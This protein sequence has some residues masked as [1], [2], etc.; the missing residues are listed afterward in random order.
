MAMDDPAGKP[1]MGE[2][3][4]SLRPRASVTFVDATQ[5]DARMHTQL[6]AVDLKDHDPDR[7]R[8]RGA[9]GVRVAAI[10]GNSNDPRTVA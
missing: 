7:C 4:A 1:M 9:H 2:A 6:V 8:E 10:R 3:G 5:G